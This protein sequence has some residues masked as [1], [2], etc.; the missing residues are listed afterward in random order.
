MEPVDRPVC[1]TL[2]TGRRH[3]PT[4]SKPFLQT[5]RSTGSI[6]VFVVYTTTYSLSHSSQS[7]HQLLCFFLLYFLN[8]QSMILIFPSYHL[9]KLYS[10]TFTLNFASFLTILPIFYLH[11][12]HLFSP[13]LST[14]RQALLLVIRFTP[15]HFLIR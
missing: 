15:I 6:Y 9:F 1:I 11:L 3:L 8:L 12:Y 2:L 5:G 7:N 4:G 14:S 13:Y 10:K